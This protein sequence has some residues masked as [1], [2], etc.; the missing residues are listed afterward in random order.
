MKWIILQ[1]FKFFMNSVCNIIALLVSLCRE[2]N[3]YNN[4]ADQFIFFWSVFFSFFSC[5]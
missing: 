4:E 1:I 2:L 5:L 3:I